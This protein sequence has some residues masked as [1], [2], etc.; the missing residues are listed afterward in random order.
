MPV[1]NRWI[2]SQANIPLVAQIIADHT[3]VADYDKIPAQYMTAIKKMF[4]SYPG[5]SHAFA[6]PAGLNALEALDE[7]YAVN[8]TA[9][10][11][12][13]EAYS[14]SY[15]RFCASLR[16][17]Q[18]GSWGEYCGEQGWYTWHAYDTPPVRWDTI[19]NHILVCHNNDYEIAAIGFGWCWDME[20]N[21]DG[22]G[23]T[24]DPVLGVRWAGASEG[25]PDGSHRWG[26]V[27]GDYALTGNRVCMDDY[28]AA[29]E[30]YIA[31]CIAESIPT[32]VF[33]TTGPVDGNGTTEE[34]Y[35]RFLKHEYIRNYVKANFSRILFDYADILCYDDDGTPNTGS[36]SGHLFPII[37][38][39]NLG[40]ADIGHIGS[41]GRLR[42]AKAL[43]WM[44]ARMAGWDG[45]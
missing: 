37:T 36:W 22:A 4:L 15:L 25:G 6:I 7:D 21:G 32:K 24:I 12:E 1:I 33:F 44:L 19:E 11:S 9:R 27:S 28:L 30:D 43:W 41:T 3:I 26:L 29:T 34:G 8:V 20:G 18:Y 5:E 13:P 14:E 10:G 16:D 39:T 2:A 35:Q 45:N 17:M 31:Y 40:S 38:T 23:G 42:L